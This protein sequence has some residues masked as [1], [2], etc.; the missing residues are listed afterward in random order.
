MVRV[1][2][3]NTATCAPPEVET[4]VIMLYS[5]LPPEGKYTDMCMTNMSLFA[6]AG[7]VKSS[8]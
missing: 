5:L 7:R 2:K 3:A 8:A 6:P 4:V 1:G